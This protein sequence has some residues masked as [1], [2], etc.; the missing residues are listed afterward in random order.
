MPHVRS[1]SI[2]VWLTRGSRHEPSA[3]AGIAHFVEHMLF[4]G[5]DESLR[6]RHRATGGFDWRTARR[7]H[8]E[9]IRRL[10]REGARRASPAG[11]RHPHRS[12]LAPGLRARGHRTREEGRAR[13]DQD[14]RGHA[15]TISCTRSSRRRSGAA[16][17][18][19]ARFSACRQRCR[20]SI[21]R[22]SS[23]YFRDAYV[24]Q[25]FVVVAVGNLEHDA[26]KALVEHAF[27]NVT[28]DGQPDRRRAAVDRSSC[29]GPTQGPR[30]EP[31]VPRNDRLAA[32]SRRSLRWPRAQHRARR[33]D[34]LA[35]VP[36][37]ARNVAAWPIRSSRR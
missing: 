27:A 26:V 34:E 22:R 32:E 20:R 3:H 8:V 19:V 16:I 24:A 14:G 10:L 2:G 6:G 37:R 17:L 29:A 9:G 35:A 5:T 4:K 33:L 36:E 12:R 28:V 18:S 31:C 21:R 1:V 30:A 15:R 7:V 13:R 23:S 25:N 11:D